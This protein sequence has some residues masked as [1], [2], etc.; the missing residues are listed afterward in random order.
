MSW[1]GP[2]HG[3]KRIRLVLT[4]DPWS[5]SILLSLI[6]EGVCGFQA[7]LIPAVGYDRCYAFA[8]DDKA[9]E[10][11]LE[12]QVSQDVVSRRDI[13][14]GGAKDEV[15]DLCYPKGKMRLGEQSSWRMMAKAEPMC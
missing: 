8:Q 3:W 1:E 2:A 11:V 5:A 14:Y 15:F 13:A 9:S 7:R 10:A 12:K 6:A 4:T